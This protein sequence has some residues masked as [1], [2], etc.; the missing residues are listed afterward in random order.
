MINK[1]Q[2]TLTNKAQARL[3]KYI[4]VCLIKRVYVIYDIL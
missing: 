1:Q 4:Q 2:L 3:F